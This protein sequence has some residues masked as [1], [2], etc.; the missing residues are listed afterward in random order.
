MLFC[1][2]HFEAEFLKVERWVQYIGIPFFIIL[3]TLYLSPYPFTIEK[4][5]LLFHFIFS[6]LG[7]LGIWYSNRAIIFLFRKKC[8]TFNFSLRLT[9]QLIVSSVAAVLITW[10]LTSL[11]EVVILRLTGLCMIDDYFDVKNLYLTVIL[12]SFLINTIYESFYLFLRLSENALE[13]ERYKNESIEAQY[14]NLTSRLNP[15]FLFNSLNTLTTI[16]EEDPKKAVNYIRELS[17]VYRHVLNSQKAA[18]SDLTAEI[19]FTKSYIT[20]LKMRF[21]DNLRIVLEIPENYLHYHILSMTIQ[22]LIENAVK[23]NEISNSHPLEI[24]IFCEDE[25][26]IVSNTKQ[27]RKIMPSTT[28]VG[29]HNISERYRFLVNKEVVI[30]DIQDT[31]LVK[32]PLVKTLSNDIEHITDDVYQ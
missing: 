16:V 2:K 17:V 11:G 29:L 5:H 10:I 30:E 14:Q 24:K 26:L 3:T 20:L 12:F 19:K 6:L 27:K 23:H 22:L 8:F 32:I 21:E 9:S 15:H 18:W 7:I 4:E 25:K 28:K 13:T 31:F 1:D